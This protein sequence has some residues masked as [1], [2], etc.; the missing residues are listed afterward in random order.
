[1]TNAET[2]AAA[3]PSAPASETAIRDWLVGRVSEHAGIAP[4]TVR[5]DESVLTY[6]IDSMR[7]VVMVGQLEEW[8]GCHFQSNPIAVYPTI[9]GL[10]HWLAAELAAGHTKLNPEAGTNPNTA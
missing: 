5:T 2:P 7:F 9:D 8:L 3:P 10:A 1:M 6:G 4:Q